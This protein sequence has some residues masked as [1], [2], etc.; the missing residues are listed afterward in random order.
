MTTPPSSDSGL[1]RGLKEL[2]G[3]AMVLGG[4]LVL[5]G[6]VFI[7]N[8]SSPGSEHLLFRLGFALTALISAGAHF[9]VFAG[10]AVLWA[11]L[12]RKA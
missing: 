12:R 1:N 9:M 2:L 7:S 3:A 6:L 10:L 4:S 11:A 5:L 8:D